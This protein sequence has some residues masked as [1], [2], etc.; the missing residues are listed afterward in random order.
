[1]PE[2]SRPPNLAS[3]IT[4]LIKRGVGAREGARTILE[5]GVNVD[6]GILLRTWSEVVRGLGNRTSV[7]LAPLSRRPGAEERTVWSTNRQRGYLY[8][9]EM[10]VQI[11]DTDIVATRMHS[12]RTQTLIT[13][14]DALDEAL[15][16]LDDAVEKY[17][18]TVLGGI[19]T[20]VYEMRPQ[21][22][23]LPTLDRLAVERFGEEAR[24]TNVPLFGGGVA[25]RGAGGRFVGG[26]E[27][28]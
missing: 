6:R 8:Q 27:T 14:G 26:I 4:P 17:G 25:V 16:F 11:A 9:M 2:P 3:L 13:Y 20:G 7:S 10:Q 24:A 23:N 22:K 21:P 19:V 1:M 15:G 18:E 5:A 12:V 28:E